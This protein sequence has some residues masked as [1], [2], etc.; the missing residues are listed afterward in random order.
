MKRRDFI[1][2][3]GG[4]AAMP[5]CRRARAGARAA[6]RRADA[7][8][9]DDPEAQARDR[10]VPAR[11][12]G[13]GLGVGRNVRID[14]RWGAGDAAR[15]RKDAAELVALKPDVILAGTG[16]T[17]TPL[18]QATRTV[19]IVFAQ[20]HRSGRRRQYR[21][22]GAAGRQ[23]HRLHPVRIQLERQM[24]GAAQGDRARDHARGRA[25]GSRHRSRDR[26]V[27]GHPGAAHRSGWS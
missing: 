15:L 7:R 3:F 6:H 14:T 21:D 22:T 26:T 2:G 8:T 16:A 9:A 24:A 23:R 19:P 10:G 1:A 20:S 12:A 17:V 18:Q 11:A 4:A 27:G 25:T 5:S 13:G